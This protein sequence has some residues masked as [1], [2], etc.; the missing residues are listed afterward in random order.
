L[1]AL[2]VMRCHLP[3]PVEC[4]GM[5]DAPLTHANRSKRA[6]RNNDPFRGAVRL[7]LIDLSMK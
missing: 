6:I 7:G 3:K 5:G 2:W 1:L 4:R